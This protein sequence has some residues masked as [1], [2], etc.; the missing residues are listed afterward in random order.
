M[1]MVTRCPTCAT[2]F[3]V[4]PQ[5]LQLRQGQVRCGRCTAVFDGFAGLAT[6]PEPV[7]SVAPRWGTS[8]AGTGEQPAESAAEGASGQTMCEVP[9][10]VGAPESPPVPAIPPVPAEF[11]FEPVVPRPPRA[12]PE[13][14]V[15]MRAATVRP[16]TNLDAAVT[17]SQT[18]GADARFLQQAHAKRRGGPHLW[19]AGSVLLLLVLLV[20]AVYLYRGELAANYRGLKPAMARMCE[21][22]ACEVPLPQRP[23]LINIEASDLQSIDRMRPGMIQLT[24]TLRNHADYDLAYPALDLVLTNTKEHTLARRIFLPREYLDQ[25]RDVNAGFPANA[26]MTVRLDLDTGD[27][28]AAG[29]RLDLLPAPAGGR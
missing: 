26:E 24:A 1:S 5:Q 28:G 15:P 17:S 21:W 11:E 10:V 7:G 8:V 9:E 2:L 25:A 12:A 3:R 27:L 6:L 18:L 23:K 20:Q 16:E 14:V 29:F 4:T 22:L 19:T 13:F